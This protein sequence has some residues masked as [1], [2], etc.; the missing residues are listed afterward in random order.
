MK[1]RIV[2][3]TIALLALVVP[4]AAEAS[5][6][7][8]CEDAAPQLSSN[9]TT[10]VV[11]SEQ[12]N[13]TEVTRHHGGGRYQVTRCDGSGDLI[14][15]QLV[16]P[17]RVPGGGTSPVVLAETKPDGGGVL[18]TRH[19][20]YGDADEPVWAEL[21][22]RYGAQDRDAV[23]P[24]TGPAKPESASAGA[25]AATAGTECTDGSFTTLGGHWGP[26]YTYYIHFA[27]LPGSAAQKDAF[28]DRIVAGH[29]V[30]NSTLNRCGF[31]DQRNVYGAYVADLARGASSTRDRFNVVDHG[32]TTVFCG[33][34]TALACAYVWIEN[35]QIQ[36][37]D[38]RY[39][40]AIPWY[41]GTGAVP[42]SQ[43]DL[44]STATHETGHTIG[45]GHTSNCDLTMGTPCG[46][47][48]Q[49]HRRLLG[50]GDVLGMRYLYPDGH[51][52]L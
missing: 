39:S 32:P 11:R 44:W 18:A 21:W 9:S 23:I 52:P 15:S 4:A 20:E 40:S 24:P 34:S 33:S 50:R 46:A 1:R 25:A 13:R 47:P 35:G 5:A 12:G 6:T 2:C 37:S 51:S 45:L 19:I 27:S 49:G 30:W 42:S 41:T 22:R 28:R 36:E 29:T 7:D 31:Q 26:I 16:A 43:Y 8:R 14:V 10:N 17:V 48:G 38:Q 3:P